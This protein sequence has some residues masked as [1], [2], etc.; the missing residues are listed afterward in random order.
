M[1]RN[2]AAAQDCQ[3]SKYLGKGKKV[4]ILLCLLRTRRLIVGVF[5]IVVGSLRYKV[6]L[7]IWCHDLALK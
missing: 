3:V 1:G 5:S 4:L 7:G 6:P 2:R